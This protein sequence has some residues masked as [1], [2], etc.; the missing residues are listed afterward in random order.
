MTKRN[1]LS[2]YEDNGEEWWNPRSKTFRSLQS[3]NAFRLGLIDEWFGDRLP[4]ATVVDLGCGGGLL[5]EPISRRGARVVGIDLSPRSVR[6]AAARPPHGPRSYV[7][8]D[9]AHAPI[10]DAVADVV[11]MA[12]V[13][14]HV[15]DVDAAL[16]EAARVLKPG[17]LLYVNTINR[18]RRAH[19]LAVTVAEG[20][21]LV[22]RGTHDPALFLCPD[23]LQKRAAA[24]GFASRRIQGEVPA[25]LATIRRWTVVLKPSRDLSVM[26]SVLFE[27]T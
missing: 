25:L 8:A 12:D 22:P 4:G 24:H 15:P 18:T 11:L 3:V 10:A 26:Y 23:D 9:V 13:L 19:L 16:A 7:C 14:E 27:K 2:I 21:G 1:D 6:T 17:G 5:A 20:V